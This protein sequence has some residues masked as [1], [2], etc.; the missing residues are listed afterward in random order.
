MRLG[1][2]SW[3]KLPISACCERVTSGGTPSRKFPNFYVNGTIPWVKTGE[4]ADWYVRA[5]DVSEW[6]TNDALERSSAKIYPPGTVLIAMYGDGSTIGTLGIVDRPLASNQACCALVPNKRICIPEYLFYSLMH[7]R[8][9]LVSLALG[10]AQRNLSGTT[11]KRFEICVPPLAVQSRIADV[12]SSYD[13]LIENNLRRIAILEETARRVYEEWFVRLRAPAC[14]RL[15]LIDSPRGPFPQG[16]KMV[17]LQELANDIRDGCLPAE[18][19]TSIPYVGLEHIPR[20]ST[21]LTEWGA[22]DGVTSLKL[23]YMHGDILFGKIR[24]YFHKVAVAPSHGVAS[25]DAIIIRAK[26]KSLRSIVLAVVSSDDFVA[27]AVQTSNGTKMPRADW[28]VLRQYAVAV[29]DGDTLAAFDGIIWPSVELAMTLAKQNRNLRAQ[30][31]LLLPK[32]ISAAID[33]S[34]AEPLLEAAE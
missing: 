32:L 26:D 17:Q 5:N 1:T 10:G 7:R 19:D 11:I 3:Q 20:R 13:Q 27:H 9:E 29:P 6:I 12:L 33:V 31:D 23:R 25:S 15:P 2:A 8:S 18:L 21:T 28:K 4:L 22:V 16:W 14:E 34:E 24:P 30:R